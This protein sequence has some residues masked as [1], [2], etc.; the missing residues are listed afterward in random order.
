MWYSPARKQ[1]WL[2][3]KGSAGWRCAN[4]SR[5]FKG[6]DMAVDHIIPVG[7][8]RCYDDIGQ[9]LQRL[10]IGAEGLQVLCEECH[11]AKTAAERQQRWYK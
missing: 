8:L 11:T 3:A 5:V 4:C 1:A 6:K 9:F 7:S 10:M 2:T